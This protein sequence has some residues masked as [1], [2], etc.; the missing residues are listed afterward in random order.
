MKNL[1]AAVYTYD[2]D[3]DCFRRHGTWPRVPYED[4]GQTYGEIS[5]SVGIG[6]WTKPRCR[7]AY[8]AT[9]E[10]EQF[11]LDIG[12]PLQCDEWK[13]VLNPPPAHRYIERRCETC[14]YHRDTDFMHWVICAGPARDMICQG[15]V[16]RHDAPP[17]LVAKRFCCKF[18]EGQTVTSPKG[19]TL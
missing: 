3:E 2:P 8:Q 10:G 7:L 18:Y 9:D 5:I 17:I 1:P 16:T 14:K 11:Y 19:E 6:L 4:M 15:L 13:P 12:L